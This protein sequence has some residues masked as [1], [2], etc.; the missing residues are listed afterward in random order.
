[1]AIMRV[2]PRIRYRRS[3][4]L[5]ALLLLATGALCLV[6]ADTPGADHLCASFGPLV[7]PVVLL[8][9]VPLGE[10]HVAPMT[11]YQVVLADLSPPPPEA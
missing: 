9:L 6:H 8:A 11:P 2:G 3:A 5:V 1:M 10:F 7:G 4:A